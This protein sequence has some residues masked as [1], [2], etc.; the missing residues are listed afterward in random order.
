MSR[1]RA[2][3]G[4]REDGQA[5]VEFAL[6]VPLLLLLLVGLAEFARAWNTKQVLTDAARE[7]LRSSVVANP[8]FTYE[9]MLDVIDQAL[10]RAALDPERAEVSMEGWKTGTGTLA[11]V[12]IDYTYELGLFGAL[13]NWAAGDRTLVLSTSF[14]MR[15]E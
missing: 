12:Q 1:L 4:Q 5:L 3:F 2:R 14:V 7:S 8:D 10:L 11:R 9:A 13:A 6:I 15:N